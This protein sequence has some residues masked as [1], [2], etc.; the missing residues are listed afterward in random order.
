MNEL[1]S[2]IQELQAEI[3]A[4]TGDDYEKYNGWADN[5]EQRNRVE[6]L[7]KHRCDLLN[8][9]FRPTAETIARFQTVNNH[10]RNLLSGL[11]MTW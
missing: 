4:I 11:Q 1:K 2:R 10:L 8:S 3:L 5:V 6:P 9:M 7:L